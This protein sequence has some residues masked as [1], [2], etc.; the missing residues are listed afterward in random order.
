MGKIFTP[1]GSRAVLAVLLVLVFSGTVAAD[2]P[3]PLRV[4]L[5]DDLYPVSFR[6]DDGEADGIFPLIIEEIS[7]ENNFSIEWVDGEWAESVER[8]RRGEID[9]MIGLSQTAERE[10]FIDFNT[11][12][13][14]A[15]WGQVFTGRGKTIEKIFDLEG[16]RVGMRFGDQNA[17]GFVDLAESFKIKYQAV[18]FDEHSEVAEALRQ[19]DVD[20]GVFYSLYW[21]AAPDL[22]PTSIVYQPTTSHF[23]IPEGAD[24]EILRLIDENLRAWK[25]DG[26]SLYY[27]RFLSIAAPARN[28]GHR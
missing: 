17:R 6:N 16:A 12:P 3:D 27:T 21:Q 24:P 23:G 10:R 18:Y 13:V 4:A 8:L 7:N 25:A 20:A 26:N 1:P 2:I 5:V 9:L 11:E 22:V 19:G 14:F 28:P 15:S